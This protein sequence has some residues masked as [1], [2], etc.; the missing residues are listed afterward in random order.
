MIKV[1]WS[2]PSTWRGIVM[3][4][5]GII[6][7]GLTLFGYTEQANQ[8]NG[9]LNTITGLISGGMVGSGAIGVLTNDKPN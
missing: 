4:A 6:V 7:G 9:I 1:D 2:Q 3:L 8:A 5:S